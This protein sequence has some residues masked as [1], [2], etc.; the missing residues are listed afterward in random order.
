MRNL[1]SIAQTP[2]LGRDNL[3]AYR[4]DPLLFAEQVGGRF[5]NPRV[6]IPFD[7]N[8]SASFVEQTVTSSTIHWTTLA[9]ETMRRWNRII[10]A[11][12]VAIP[13]QADHSISLSC[14]RQ[15]WRALIAS[16]RYEEFAS[17]FGAEGTLPRYRGYR[18]LVE[19]P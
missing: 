16:M 1:H 7:M 19:Y 6:A 10:H 18:V 15:E 2:F 11:L 14:T 4:G 3:A 8:M 12:Q 9:E 17:R 13:R 5:L